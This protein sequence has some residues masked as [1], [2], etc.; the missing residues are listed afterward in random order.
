M[1]KYL[2]GLCLLLIVP[3]L[4]AQ[5]KSIK[6]LSKISSEQ[7]ADATW[8]VAEKQSSD[9]PAKWDEGSAIYLNYTNV[10]DVERESNTKIA[11][12]Q[13]IHRK[14]KLLDDSAIEYFSEITFPG[15]EKETGF[16][17]DRTA[18]GVRIIKKNGKIENIQSENYILNEDDNT[19]KL[20]VPNLETGD[21]LEYFIYAKDEY[22]TIHLGSRPIIYDHFIIQRDYPILHYKYLVQTETGYKTWLLSSD[23]N[24]KIKDE[25]SNRRLVLYVEEETIESA[26]GEIWYDPYKSLPNLKV[27]VNSFKNGSYS[28]GQPLYRN[29]IMNYTKDLFYISSF[30]KTIEK[31]YKKSLKKRRAEN[32]SAGEALKDYYYFL[33]HLMEHR[34]IMSQE[35]NERDRNYSANYFYYAMIRKMEDLGINYRYIAANQGDD[36]E[37]EDIINTSELN[38]LVKAEIDGGVFFSYL[39]PFMSYGYLPYYLEGSDAFMVYSSAEYKKNNRSKK[40]KKIKLPRSEYKDNGMNHT[41]VVDFDADDL[42]SANVKTDVVLTGHQYPNYIYPL[43]DWYDQ[44]WQEIDNFETLELA[45]SSDA[46]GALKMQRKKVIENRK[47]YMMEQHEA[48]AKNHYYEDIKD[49]TNGHSKLVEED[50]QATELQIH[51]DC[52]M[53]NLMKKVGNNFILKIGKLVGGQVSIEDEPRKYDVHMDY[54]RM[55]DYKVKINLPEGYTVDGL[56]DV[57]TAINNDAGMFTLSHELN[58]QELTFRFTKVYKN[59]FQLKSQW[60]LMANFLKPANL[61]ESKEILLRKQ[62]TAK[63]N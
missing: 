28:K 52:K 22:A 30:D 51:F 56:E 3:N 9:Y 12:T 7:I 24:I 20:A 54:P 33:R 46:K 1:T 34:E 29:E 19:K 8:R 50:G 6:N 42:T 16:K 49:I 26:E 55:F 63:I 37:L 23:E 58:G 41:S 39:S 48:Y 14:V 47:E 53:D 15:E 40:G 2:L 32:L 4:C 62:K 17:R 43:V 45:N 11:V 57:N 31:A 5:H 44:I 18:S 13:L 36:N 60:H 61:F 59:D 35:F 38:Y 27:Q 25:H 10:Y 21:I